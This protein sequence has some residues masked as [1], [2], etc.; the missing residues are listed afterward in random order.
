MKDKIILLIAGIG[1]PLG[2]LVLLCRNFLGIEEPEGF[3]GLAAGIGLFFVC[4]IITVIL[5][6]A[7][8]LFFTI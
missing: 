3:T 1:L 2:I 6:I 8:I 7:T 4:G 5:V